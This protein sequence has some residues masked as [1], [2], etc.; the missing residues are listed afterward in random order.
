MGYTYEM[1]PVFDYLN[2]TAVSARPTIFDLSREKEGTQ[3]TALFDSGAI[4]R[5]SDDYRGQLRELFA[6]DN[7]RLAHEPSF[8]ERFEAY[9][10]GLGDIRLQGCWVYF[11]WN[12]SLA[13]VLDKECFYRVRTARNR[14]L[15]TEREQKTYYDAHIGIAGLSVG[16]SV[17]LAIA[18]SG[19][20]RRMRLADMDTFA[21]SNTN[22]VPSSVCD[23]GSKKVELAARRIY[24]INPYAEIELEPRGV[25]I[26]TIEAFFDGLD[27]V[28]DEVDDIAAKYLIRREAR[29]RGIPLVMAA[30]NGDGAVVDIERYDLDKDT[31]F[32]HGRLGDASYEQLSGLDRAGVGRTITKHIGHENVTPR[33]QES[34]LEMGK[35]IVSWPQLGG[36]A[37]L[38]GAA[39]AYCV[40]R[41]VNG[42]EVQH[43]RATISF[44]EIFVPSYA[45]AGELAKRKATADSFREQFKL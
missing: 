22:R 45:S 41:I 16:T 33:M 30:D 31:P 26:E 8:E 27:V 32:F 37:L 19:G 43:N 21:L 35:T 38:N 20:G 5:V 17:A 2:S 18:L 10:S 6:V 39:V 40:R 34:L 25:S 42:Q 1:A 7:P 29:K 36:A 4:R 9:L 11:P 28:V 15:I 13:H 14:N 3:L 12:A 24:E 44:D 23:L